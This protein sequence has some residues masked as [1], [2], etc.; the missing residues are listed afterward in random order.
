MIVA[1]LGITT[2]VALYQQVLSLSAGASVSTVVAEAKDE[3]A[4]PKVTALGR[5]EPQGGVID[6]APNV[7]GTSRILVSELHVKLGDWVEAG[8][9]IAVLGNHAAHQAA[10]V[11]AQQQV[12]TAAA[13]LAQVQAG[14]KTGD[15]QVQEAAIARL[16]AQLQGDILAQQARITRLNAE[17]ENTL[18]NNQRYQ[19]LYDEGAISIAELESRQTSFSMVQAQ[20]S[21]AQTVLAQLQSA[22]AQEIRQAEATLARI[23]EIRPADITLANE[24]LNTAIASLQSAQIAL[25]QTYVRAPVAGQILQVYV[26]AGELVTERGVVALGQTRQM[27]AIAEVYETDINRIRVGQT[28]TVKSEYGGFDGTLHGVVEDIGL[29][30]ARNRMIDVTPGSPIDTRVIEV[31]VRLSPED[32]DRVRALTD[33]Q[34]RMYI[35]SA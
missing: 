21:E 9:L 8:E 25:D 11:E 34:V 31:T 14:A 27:V 7:V 17:L 24:E 5:L 13:R 16:N 19:G 23:Q 26:Q 10:V 18:E 4:A 30:V 15:I 29:R 6:V 28:A 20:V 35:D 32:S 2:T 3:T 22:G 1:L 12:N 33:L